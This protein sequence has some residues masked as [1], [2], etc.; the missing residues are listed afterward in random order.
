MPIRQLEPDVAA[1]IAAGEVV[2]RPASVVKELIENSIDAGATQIRVDLTHGGLQLIRVTDNGGGIAVEELPLALARHATSKVAV[3]DD[4]EHIRTLGFRGEALAS[5]AAVAEVTLLSRARGAQQGASVSAVNGQISEPQVAAAAEGT[6]LT[7]RNLFSAVPARLKFLKSR[8]TEVS[9]CLHMLEQYA[10]AYPEIRFSVYSEGRQIF[11]TPG[12]GQLASVLIEIYGLQVAEQMVPIS[13]LEGNEKDNDPERPVVSGYT[14]LPA[15]YKST[16]QYI[17]FFVNRRWVMSRVLTGAVEEA[18]H[19]LLLTGR[20]PIS[21]VNVTLDPSQ[22]DVNVHPAKTEI[23][24]LRER[25]VYAAVLRA[26]R[27]ALLAQAEMPRWSRD[28]EPIAKST[29]TTTTETAETGPDELDLEL[30]LELEESEDGEVPVAP[31]AEQ[32]ADS[33]RAIPQDNPWLTVTEEETGTKPPLLSRLWQSHVR[34]GESPDQPPTP[35]PR[36]FPGHPPTAG[37]PPIAGH[38][39]TAGHPQGDGPTIPDGSPDDT[40]ARSIVGPSLAGGL[41]GGAVDGDAA[42]LRGGVVDGDAAGLRGGVVDG[43]A[44]GLRGGAVDGDAAGLRGGAVDGGTAGLGSVGGLP[45]GGKLMAGPG[46][47]PPLRVIGQLSQSYIVTEGPDGMYLI[48]QHAAHER[49]LLE[50]MVAALQAR[51]PISQMLLTPIRLE[52]APA[53]V[54]ALEEHLAQL[55]QIGFAL[56]L[57]DG[58][59]LVKAVPNVLVKQMNAR[60]LRELLA[61]LTAVEQQGHT[62]TWEEHALANVACKAAIKANYFLTVSEMREMLSQLEQTKA[63]YS[64]CHGRPTMVQFSLSALEREFGRR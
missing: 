28:G 20:H 48:D 25:R 62:G 33:R 19:S 36:P 37:H 10:L 5:I 15:C 6:T 29:K 56:E 38:P 8:N 3:I 41:R 1:K 55:E 47:L 40:D 13:S 61:D 35:D 9:H 4:L 52:L 30:E 26:V 59:A 31:S 12:D 63:P 22:L 39:P 24:F 54:E 32:S 60:S 46:K 34:N 45:G 51:T 64:C 11:A 49:I 57:L 18:Y 58:A 43:D 2:E 16:R 14:S 7:V 17:S 42:G 23:R 53:E 27:N 44:A 21:V 50:R